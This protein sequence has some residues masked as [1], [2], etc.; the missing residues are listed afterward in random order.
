MTA[1][2]PPPPS[3][4][5]IPPPKTLRTKLATALQEVAILRRLIRVAE[6]VPTNGT[7]SLSTTEA[8]NV[9]GR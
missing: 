7:P 3:A 6:S 2:V 1:A 8:T 5:L 9:A 4:A